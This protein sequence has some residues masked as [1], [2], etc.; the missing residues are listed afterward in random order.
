M[1]TLIEEIF[2]YLRILTKTT[3]MS[4]YKLISE[5]AINVFNKEKMFE[6]KCHND[7]IKIYS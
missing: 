1:L 3:Q 2:S 4:R 6:V 5:H 7:F